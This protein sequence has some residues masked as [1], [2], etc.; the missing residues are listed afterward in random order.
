M[1][2]RIRVAQLCRE[3]KRRN[4][5]TSSRLCQNV[6]HELKD[7]G[8]VAAVTSPTLSKL[9][10]NPTC[11][12]SGVDPS[13]KSL[14]VGNLLPLL[15]L[16]H[17]KEAGHHVLALIG[18]ATGSIGDPS[19]RST[20][21]NA[22]DKA[23]VE[24]NV[25]SITHQ[26]ERFFSL[27]NTYVR[28]RRPGT[29]GVRDDQAKAGTA[30]KLQVVNNHEWTVGVSLLDFL[31][32]VGKFAKVNTMLSRESVK[33]RL[34]AEQ[35]ISFTEFTY[36]LLQAFDFRHL[37]SRYRCRVQVG[38]SD[39]WGNI[40]SGIDLI[41]R[42][43]AVAT[44]EAAKDDLDP[45]YGLT[46]PLLTTST[47]EKFGK[48][49]GNAVWLDQE[50]TSVFDFY[51]YFLRT[52]DADVDKLLRLFTFLP[53]SE[54]EAV[55]QHHSAKPHLRTAQR[56]LAN[57]ITQLVHGEQG[58]AK[59]QTATAILYG[60]NFSDLEAETVY[61][62]L[63]GDDRLVIVEKQ[64]VMGTPFARLAASHGL[65]KSNAEASRSIKGGG[66]YV[67]NQKLTDT[68]RTLQEDD[69]LDE[70]LVVL[71]IGKGERKILYLT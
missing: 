37:H 24:A 66:F 69:L 42:T 35:G 21:R 20:E 2:S 13:A 61:Q 62:A 29:T 7:R 63:H 10:E 64:T 23:V 43:A 30:G 53:I 50:M 65:A 54:I 55:L 19:G 58:L 56:L 31:R 51:Q 6:L 36:Q 17:M 57:E 4:I 44:E 39:Q 25:R 40:V 9:L 12:Y 22:L 52:P 27:G 60:S 49:A 48:S 38:G 32:D 11:I 16:L 8:F 5:H 71:A 1:L 46:I 47:G 33:N 67:N 28:S 18:G 70:R 3:L 14:H 45:A 34:T 41:R 59:A 68:T 26:V 15:T